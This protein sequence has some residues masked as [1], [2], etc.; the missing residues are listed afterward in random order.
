MKRIAIALTLALLACR[1]SA[2]PPSIKHVIVI[3]LENEQRANAEKQPYFAELMKRG[4]MLRNFSAVAHPSRPNYIAMISGST[5]GVK[6]DDMV[7]I[8]A[9]HLG[10]LLEARRL[11]WKV[12][13]ENYPGNCYLRDSARGSYARRHTGFLD[14]RNVQTDPARCARVV[15]AAELDRDAAAGKLPEFALYVPNNKNNGHDT[16]VSVADKFLRRR[17]DPLLSDPNYAS[18][19]FVVT[20]DEDDY[21]AK[22]HIYTV[23]LGAGVKPGRVTDVAY[24]HYSL[25]RT[26]E[27]LFH[28]GN[29]GEHDAGAKV[30]GE[31]WK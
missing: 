15:E 24:D 26:I 12:Y 21:H 6:N 13:A 20:F 31:V 14:F 17:L 19:L 5:H 23:L 30:I 25:L 10:D 4:A 22:N 18:T 28:L 8:D 7:T 16:D 27:E 9:R 1:A 3:V 11:N 29:L 2:L